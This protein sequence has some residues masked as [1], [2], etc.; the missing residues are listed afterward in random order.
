[1]VFGPTL[2]GT[3]S[4]Q[5]YLS[6]TSQG[7]ELWRANFFQSEFWTRSWTVR[8]YLHEKLE[9]LRGPL[10]ALVYPGTRKPIIFVFKGCCNWTIP[11]HYI[12]EEVWSFT[13]H[14]FEHGFRVPG[15]H[16]WSRRYSPCDIH[17][18]YFGSSWSSFVEFPGL[19]KR[20]GEKRAL[21]IYT[22]YP[23]QP[24]FSFRCLA[25]LTFFYRF[26]SPSHWNSHLWMVVS[27]SRRKYIIMQ[28]WSF[29]Q[30]IPNLY[31]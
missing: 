5:S 30:M 15:S 6:Q 9:E 22:W 2:V 21:V 10:N 20:L 26:G 16:I 17:V 13:N 1:M 31:L 18:H 4:T 14:P 19:F 23:K 11:N 27:S 24:V 29:N 3:L 28:V 8:S 12:H 7:K 25:K